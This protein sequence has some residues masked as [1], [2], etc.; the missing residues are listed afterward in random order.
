MK[1]ASSRGIYAG[2][3]NVYKRAVSP[4]LSVAKCQLSFDW[5]QSSASEQHFNIAGTAFV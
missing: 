4:A 2:D 1:N 3:A 5:R